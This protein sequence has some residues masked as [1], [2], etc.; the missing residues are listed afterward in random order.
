MSA[1][2]QYLK[3]TLCY[4]RQK[5]FRSGLVFAGGEKLHQAHIDELQSCFQNHVV[6]QLGGERY[7]FCDTHVTAKQGKQLLGQECQLLICDFSAEFDANS[8]SAALGT[9]CG[10]GLLV[11]FPPVQ[12]I[13]NCGERWLSY[14]LEQLIR[15][16]PNQDFSLLPTTVETH[17]LTQINTSSNSFEQQQQAISLIERVVDGHRKRPLVLTADRG[18]GKT[19]ALGMASATL[20]KRRSIKIV[21]TAPSRQ[22]VEPLFVHCCAGLSIEA[23]HRNRIEYTSSTLEFIAPDTL[24]ESKIECDLL[25]VDEASAIPI[26]MLQSLVERYH[27][28]VLSTTIHGYEGCGRGFSLKFCS[29]LKQVRP[30]SRFFH[31]DQPIRWHRNDPL[32]HWFYQSFLLDAELPKIDAFDINQ[33]VAQPITQQELVE[34]SSLLKQLFAL[35]VHAHYQTTPNDL[36]LMLADRSISIVGA[37]SQ[38]QLVGCALLIEEGSLCL[39]DIQDIQR[40]KRR[41]KGQLVASSLASQLGLS[42]AASSKSYRIM[43]I[44]VHPDWQMHGIGRY[45]LRYLEQHIDADFLSTSFGATQQL[46]LFWQHNGFVPLRIGSHRDQASG[47]HSVIMI[48][49]CNGCLWLQSGRKIFSQQL[50]YLLANTLSKLETDI[51]RSL[52]A[53]SYAS[54]ETTPLSKSV[55]FYSLGGASFDSVAPFIAQWIFSNIEQIE[56]VSDLIIRKVIQ[57]RSWEECAAEFSYLGRKQTESAL[58]QQLTKLSS[59]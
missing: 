5:Q 24:L 17:S 32:E 34:Q 31:I 23:G 43:R 16:E 7:N 25:L 2:S 1:F 29:W 48:K 55:G 14:C 50:Q 58:R 4:L 47:C 53:M 15:I 37:Y 36:M 57:Q 46:L 54:V 27:R 51:V 28:M 18:R 41:P 30:Q 22:A 49:P 42:E 19:S 59:N 45:I 33:L 10:G 20:M 13:T 11:I 38:Q 6:F 39:D 52:V 21:V 56:S 9:L 35:L 3:T 8:F 40:G 44:A 26:S 12:A